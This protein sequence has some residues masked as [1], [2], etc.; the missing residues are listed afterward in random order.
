[1]KNDPDVQEILNDYFKIQNDLLELSDKVH[2]K[3]NSH[4][5][6]MNSELSSVIKT[7]STDMEEVRNKRQEFQTMFENFDQKAN[8][9]FN[10]LSTVLKSIKEMQS[11]VTRNLL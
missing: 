8:Q 5:Q 3:F 2:S 1:M 10:I 11:G 6:L 7:M 4:T 9:L